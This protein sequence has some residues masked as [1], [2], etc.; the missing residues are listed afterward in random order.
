[1]QNA[2]EKTA[3][4]FRTAMKE[5]GALGQPWSVKVLDFGCGSGTLVHCFLA[6]GFDAYGCDIEP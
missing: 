3:M 4:F 5:I 2:P 6:L 1:M